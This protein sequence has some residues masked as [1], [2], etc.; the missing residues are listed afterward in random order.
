[1]ASS[2]EVWIGSA[3]L[4]LQSKKIVLP[5]LY[6]SSQQKPKVFHALKL[7]LA[8]STGSMNGV[9]VLKVHCSDPHLIVQLKF[10]KEENCRKFLQSYREGALQKSLQ[11]HLQLTLSMPTISVETDLKT[12][13]E[14][15]DRMLNEVEHC[16]A[17]IYKEKPDRLRDEEIAELEKS[18]R[19]LTCRQEN[20]VVVAKKSNSLNSSSLPYSSGASSLPQGTTFIFQ[21]QHFAN[22]TL[23][24][25]DHQK[26]AKLVSKKWKQVGRSLQKNCRALRDPVIDNLALEYDR[27]GLYEQAYQLLLKFIQ[28][29]GKRAT[30]QRLIAALEENSLIHLAEELLGLHHSDNDTS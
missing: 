16:L 28:S 19:S 15:L 4:F 20:N 18:L 27:E 10:C 5:S 13:S 25:D 29:E 23:T 14:H 1:M 8:D 24:R 30:L 12:G 9:D 3:Y 7:A 21:G 6:G 11:N 2:S 22:R 26:F 17:C